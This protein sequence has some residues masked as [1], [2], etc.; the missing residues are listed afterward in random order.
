MGIKWVP[1]I[2]A[3]LVAL[4]L[5]SGSQPALQFVSQSIADT[6][7]GAAISASKST[8]LQKQ[9]SQLERELKVLR[10]EKNIV[11]PDH[12]Q[13]LWKRLLDLWNKG[14]VTR[15]KAQELYQ[16]LLEIYTRSQSRPQTGASPSHQEG[17]ATGGVDDI[18]SLTKTTKGELDRIQKLSSYLSESHYQ[19]LKKKLDYLT[20]KGIKDLAPYYTILEERSPTAIAEGDRAA[21]AARE[22]EEKK[23]ASQRDGV[24]PPESGCRNDPVVLTRDITDF[25]TIKTITAPGTPV[26]GRDVAKGHSFI[27]TGGERVPVYAPI[28]AV[29]ESMDSGPQDGV[30]HSTLIFRVKGNCS[31]VFRFAHITEPD[32]SFA[33]GTSLPAGALIGY[34][35]GNVP[36]GNWDFGLYDLAKDGPL[37]KI[38][39]F[40]RHRFG[41]CWIDY[42]S[43]EKQQKYRSLL[44]GPRIVCSF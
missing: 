17:S 10:E 5:L 35:V 24:L 18:E 33:I 38:N 20:S 44:E 39:A 43:S 29:L 2:V 21:Q 4:A 7:F 40:G 37:A 3:G 41:L 11:G 28:D 14:A 23:R 32:R 26:S 16:V 15:P 12:I 19:G 13:R 34:T 25:S 8:G 22:A 42:Y 30:T 27:W 9:V 36:S 31:F 1:T 6:E